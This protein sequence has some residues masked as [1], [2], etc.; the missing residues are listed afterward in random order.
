MALSMKLPQFFLSHCDLKLSGLKELRN[1]AHSNHVGQPGF[2]SGSESEDSEND[3]S[4]I[5]IY[6]K[7]RRVDTGPE[8]TQMRKLG[9]LS[10][11]QKHEIAEILAT[12]DETAK[13]K[14]I[15]VMRTNGQSLSVS[16]FLGL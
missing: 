3:N 13:R 5:E 2:Q 1:H 15:K 16:C 6:H 10:S 8:V 12:L 14:A 7:R 4:T 11:D 9:Q